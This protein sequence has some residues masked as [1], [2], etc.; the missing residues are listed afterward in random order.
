MSF[1]SFVPGSGWWGG[2]RLDLTPRPAVPLASPPSAHTLL[3]PRAKRAGVSPVANP[4]S[5]LQRTMK[6]SPDRF[7]PLRVAQSPPGITV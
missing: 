7:L 5:T 6:A 4:V 3:P 2:G 1:L